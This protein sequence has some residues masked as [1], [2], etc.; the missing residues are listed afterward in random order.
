MQNRKR[1]NR[2]RSKRRSIFCPI[3]GCYIDS[4]SQK[5]PLY[6]N[7]AEQ[8][9]ERGISRRNASMLIANRT[10][11]TLTGEWLEAFWCEECQQNEWYWVKRSAEGHYELT[12]I[13]ADLWE[14]AQGVILADGNPTVSQ[15]TRRHSRQTTYRG[16]KDFSEFR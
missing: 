11:V 9:R 4:V 15:F 13:P 14:R 12:S 8:L 5:H 2:N 16:M 1:R 6:A 3:H 10:T 7:K